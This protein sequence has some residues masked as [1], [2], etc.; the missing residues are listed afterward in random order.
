MP[1]GTENKV[2]RQA[3]ATPCQLRRTL[4]R[5]HEDTG[6]VV[7]VRRVEGSKSCQPPPFYHSLRLIVVLARRADSECRQRTPVWIQ[8]FVVM[9]TTCLCTWIRIPH[10]SGRWWRR[11]R[12]TSMTRLTASIFRPLSLFFRYLRFAQGN[13]IPAFT[14]CSFLFNFLPEVARIDSK[15]SENIVILTFKI[16]YF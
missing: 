4:V 8:E 12:G 7:I 15:R 5:S 6:P 13:G 1:F 9:T 3:A 14:T 11:R 16:S 2:P 10:L